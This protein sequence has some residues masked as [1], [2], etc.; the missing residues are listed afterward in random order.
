MRTGKKVT[1]GWGA[2][3]KKVNQN[4]VAHFPRHHCVKKQIAHSLF[5][6]TFFSF[7]T[8]KDEIITLFILT[9]LPL[10][11][12][13]TFNSISQSLVCYFTSMTRGEKHNDCVLPVQTDAPHQGGEK[14]C[15]N[16]NSSPWCHQGYWLP[17]DG[18]HWLELELTPESLESLNTVG[19]F[20][21]EWD[22]RELWEGLRGH[23]H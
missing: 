16:G 7:A 22:P 14:N 13:I 18:V 9:F 3:N 21:G 17:V 10:C 4:L 15:S 19:F 23:I 6:L 2:E 5:S 12:F 11:F 20:F 8:Y 1:A